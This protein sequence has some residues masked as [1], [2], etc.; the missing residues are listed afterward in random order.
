M[1]LLGVKC[2]SSRYRNTMRLCVFNCRTG[3]VCCGKYW[4]TLQRM[5]IKFE[6]LGMVL[7]NKKA[8]IIINTIMDT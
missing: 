6:I 7:H 5:C 3:N 2:V 4:L 1:M 8:E